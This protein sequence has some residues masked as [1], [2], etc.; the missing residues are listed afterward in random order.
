MHLRV[1]VGQPACV[2]SVTHLR[3]VKSGNLGFSTLSI[4]GK[5][6]QN[7]WI[8]K[9]KVVNQNNNEPKKRRS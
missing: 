1:P 9:Q 4:L 8:T 7:Q 5:S 2:L 6:K 3:F